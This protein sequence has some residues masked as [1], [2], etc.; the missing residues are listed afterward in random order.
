VFDKFYRGR[1]EG[2][3]GGAG[4]GLTICRAIARAH[5]GEIEARNQAAGGG[6]IF[7]VTLP[8]GEVAP[9]VVAEA[10]E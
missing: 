5:G 2:N 7:I 3:V 9:E 4:L 6:A 10:P 1:R 8:R